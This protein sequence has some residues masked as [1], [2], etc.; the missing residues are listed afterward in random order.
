MVFQSPKYQGHQ[1]KSFQT[2]QL[3]ALND[4][5]H[6]EKVIL[7]SVS[8]CHYIQEKSPHGQLRSLRP[9][10]PENK[11]G[12]SIQLHAR[13][14]HGVQHYLT[15][16]SFLQKLRKPTTPQQCRSDLEIFPLASHHIFLW[17]LRVSSS[18]DYKLL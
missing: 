13:S 10:C 18:P 6:Q 15:P 16:A 3:V 12:L 2:A 14:S 8:L 5:G 9:K 4:P 17:H 1:N 11:T 7:H